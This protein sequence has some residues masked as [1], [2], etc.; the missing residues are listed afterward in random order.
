MATPSNGIKVERSS[1]IVTPKARASY[2]HVFKPSAF[3]GEGEPKFSIN[4]LVPKTNDEFIKN[5]RGLQDAATKALYPP[6]KKPQNFEVWGITD[7][8]ETDDSAAAGCWVIKASNKSRPA[9][10]DKDAVQIIDE[11][12]VY[13]GC[14]VRANINAKA[15]G[16]ASKG[17][18]TLELNVVQKIADGEAF[19]GAAAVKAKALEEMGAYEEE[20][21]EE[22]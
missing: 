11:L 5:L 15:Y 8:D 18:V 21:A 16:T 4:L 20:L 13:G 9:I 22:F 14:Y 6:T 7:G 10:V 1:R 3:Q 2:P 17:G 19:G 12:E